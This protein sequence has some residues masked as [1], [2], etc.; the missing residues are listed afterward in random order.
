MKKKL[1]TILF[2]IVSLSLI[3]NDNTHSKWNLSVE[4]GLNRFDGDINQ[5]LI[6]TFPASIWNLTSGLNIEYKLTEVW[7]ISISGYYIPIKADTY[8]NNIQK[9]V[10]TKISA[11]SLNTTIDFTHLIFP[12]SKSKLTVNGS[13]G[14]GYAFYV[15]N[16]TPKMTAN[17]INFILS[18]SK[19]ISPEFPVLDTY[20]NAFTLPVSLYAKYNLSKYF[21]I[22]IKTTYICFNKDNLEGIWTYKG[23]TNDGIGLATL[24]VSYKF[25][26]IEYSDKPIDLSSKVNKL[27][28][29]LKNLNKQVDKQNKKIDSLSAYILNKKENITE[30][31]TII[32]NVYS[33]YFDFD[34]SNLDDWA[35]I[36]IS[37]VAKQMIDNPKDRIVIV[38]YCDW[39]GTVPYN[40][41]LSD[42]R[43]A[44]AKN[45]LINVWG[46]NPGRITTNGKGKLYD[47]KMKYRPNRRCDFIF[48]TL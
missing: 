15:Y 48:G 38:G 14:L 31:D 5:P 29:D 35:L 32:D 33:I 7:G 30:R 10:R 34:K 21:D 13:V 28:Y 39:M 26:P 22:G 2:L 17:D 27:N 11:S 47:P 43:V 8:L 3:A 36:T 42:R 25:N 4:A 41:N 20:G 24:F 18:P 44:R 40:Y 6:N 16:T 1:L 23:V 45:E 46:I 19:G 9:E 12:Y 37:K